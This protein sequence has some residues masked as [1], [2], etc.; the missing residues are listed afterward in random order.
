MAIVVGQKPL[1]WLGVPD[2]LNLKACFLKKRQGSHSVLDPLSPKSK[3]K[4]PSLECGHRVLF[5]AAAKLPIQHQG[6]LP[7]DRSCLPE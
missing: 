4:L 5:L 7:K 2:Q 1:P 3:N 6:S